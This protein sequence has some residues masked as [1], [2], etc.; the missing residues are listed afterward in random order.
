M[1]TIKLQHAAK[2]LE[3]S[4]MPVSEVVADSGYEDKTYF[5]RE[6]RKKYG[7]TPAEYRR[8]ARTRAGR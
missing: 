5:Y 4:V 2:L 8:D 1:K 3:D 7:N 6:F